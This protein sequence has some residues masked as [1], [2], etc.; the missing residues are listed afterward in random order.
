VAALIDVKPP[1]E[2]VHGRRTIF[3]AMHCNDATRRQR[4]HPHSELAALHAVDL[5][6]KVE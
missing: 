4:E 3:M 6:A 1:H 2:E 5:R